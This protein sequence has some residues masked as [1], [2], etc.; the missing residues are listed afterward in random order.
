MTKNDL[1]RLFEHMWWADERVLKTL[2]SQADPP[3]R[4]VGLYG[5]ILA[6]EL[7][8]LERIGGVP[9]NVPV[10]PEVDLGMCQSMAHRARDGYGAFVA[11]LSLDRMEQ[12]IHYTTTT[13]QSFETRLDDILLHVA[14]HGPYHRGQI[15]MLLRDAGG[16]PAPTDYIVFLRSVPAAG[17]ATRSMP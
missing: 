13:G 2:T 16:N 15:A 4:A 14:L 10:W 8:W 6:A 9:A 1:R 7:V 17:G 11:A 12:V 5:H 3:A